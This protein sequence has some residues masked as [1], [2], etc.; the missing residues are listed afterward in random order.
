MIIE[1]YRIIIYTFYFLAKNIE[2]IK[3]I[4]IQWYNSKKMI[5]MALVC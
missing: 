4:L 3:T 1:G 2:K 5:Y